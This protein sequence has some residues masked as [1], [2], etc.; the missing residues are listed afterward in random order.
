MRSEKVT[1]ADDSYDVVISIRQATVLDGMRRAIIEVEA[2]VD[3]LDLVE[4]KY[5]G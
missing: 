5:T 4:E 3:P 1:Y 2:A